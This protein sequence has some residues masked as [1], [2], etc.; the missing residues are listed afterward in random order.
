MMN[1]FLR[2]EFK[3]LATLVLDRH[4]A[5]NRVPQGK[6]LVTVILTEEASRRLFDASEG[7]VS[8][9][10]LREMDVLWPGFSSEVI[11]TRV[12]RWQYGGVQL[13]PGVLGQQQALRA[14]LADRFKDV[15][16]A[17]DGL[18]RASMEV[19]LRTGFRAAEHILK[20]GENRKGIG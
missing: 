10:V 14:E 7:L 2:S 3:V 9:E 11:F 20:S 1:N 12:Y 18:Y 13:P 4:K 17:G 19:S 6:G 8:A 16:F 5:P 15:A